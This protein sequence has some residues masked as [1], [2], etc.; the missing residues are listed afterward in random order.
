MPSFHSTLPSSGKSY[1]NIALMPLRQTSKG[2]ARGP[3]PPSTQEDI[4][5]QTLGLFKVNNLLS[6]HDL[7]LLEFRPTFSLNN[8]IW[9]LTWTGSW[10]M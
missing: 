6:D 7:N 3:A 2:T 8:S 1:G 5:D 4:V 9:R 10:S